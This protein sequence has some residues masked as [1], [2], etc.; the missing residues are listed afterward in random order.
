MRKLVAAVATLALGSSLMSA[1]AEAAGRWPVCGSW[2]SVTTRGAIGFPR[3]LVVVSPY[4][5]WFSGYVGEVAGTPAL[6]R[7]TGRRWQDEPFPL[8]SD[9]VDADVAGLT[10]GPAGRTW[11]V[12]EWRARSRPHP[13]VARWTGRRW[14]RLRRGLGGLVGGLNAAAPAS[15]HTA[16]AVGSTAGSSAYGAARGT[17]LVLRW[18]GGRW[19]R[20][21]SPRPG[22]ASQFSDVVVVGG[23][24]WAVGSYEDR[25][26]T[27]RTLAAQRHAGRWRTFL[28]RAGSLQA[29]DA[30][31]PRLV[32]AVGPGKD[33]EPQRAFVMRWDGD[34]WATV[35][36]FGRGS[37]L[38]D[39]VVASPTDAWAVGYRGGMYDAPRPLVLRRH[40]SPWGR[41]PAP[42][43]EGRF[44]AVDGTPHN[45]WAV[46]W[47][48][49]GG[50]GP[51]PLETFHRC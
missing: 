14:E 42:A 28:G 8:P 24:L 19:H 45:V 12:G 26:G 15:A 3:A 23:D 36:V 39:I 25:A 47:S 6:V 51:P 37:A 16:W 29:V 20:V 10:V 2:R 33:V 5:A 31:G 17:T 34:V 50:D 44:W 1:P 9:A 4:E 41:S 49:F 35:R 48:S 46:A 38:Q 18:N 13:L 7:W 27:T 22:R 32:W 43:Y 30:A 11:A 40:G 21:A